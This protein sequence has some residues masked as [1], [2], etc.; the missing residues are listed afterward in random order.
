[1]ARSK[2]SI[3]LVAENEVN[4]NFREEINDEGENKEFERRLLEEEEE[5]N[6]DQN[7]DSSENESEATSETEQSQK[8]VPVITN[9]ML[10]QVLLTL[11]TAGNPLTVL[12]PTLSTEEQHLLALDRAYEYMTCP[13]LNR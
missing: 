10:Q 3:Q 11:I 12:P 2:E 4:D 9:K 5:E 7:V 6:S 13:L 1:L 8:S